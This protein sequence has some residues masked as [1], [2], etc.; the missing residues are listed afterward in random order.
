VADDDLFEAC[1]N[2]SAESEFEASPG[3]SVLV[4]FKWNQFGRK[5]YLSKFYTSLAQFLVFFV[6][7]NG[8]VYERQFYTG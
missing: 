8:L 3:I 7:C 6:F 4:D 2:A 1:F 5:E